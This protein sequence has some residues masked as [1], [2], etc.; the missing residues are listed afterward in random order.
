MSGGFTTTGNIMRE[1][2]PKHR[3]ASCGAFG[4]NALCP[5]H[6]A[7][8]VETMD[9]YSNGLWTLLHDAHKKGLLVKLI[10]ALTDSLESMVPKTDVPHS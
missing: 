9:N 5:K 8:H 4:D 2:A 10:S 6:W 3:C 1:E 7:V